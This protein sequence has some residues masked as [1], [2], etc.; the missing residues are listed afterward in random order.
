MPG[1]WTDDTSMAL[2]VAESVVE[3]QGYNPID[4]LIRFCG[5]YEGGYMNCCGEL[6]DIGLILFL[7]LYIQYNLVSRTRLIE[8]P[9]IR[10]LFDPLQNLLIL[11]DTC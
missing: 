8:F 11:N 3:C 2:C 6:I 4:Q 9:L 1:Q 10:T 5:W 7:E